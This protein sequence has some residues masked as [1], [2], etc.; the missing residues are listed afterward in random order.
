M[1]DTYLHTY[2]PYSQNNEGEPATDLASRN[3]A[4][5]LLEEEA[6]VDP[7]NLPESEGVSHESLLHSQCFL[8]WPFEMIKTHKFS[9][10]C[11]LFL[12]Q[13]EN[14]GE[15]LPMMRYFKQSHS[16]SPKLF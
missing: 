12:S 8:S 6:E 14:L 16:D 10:M 11:A 2:K 3:E 1:L 13:F 15:R 7:E 4:V 9:L 5:I